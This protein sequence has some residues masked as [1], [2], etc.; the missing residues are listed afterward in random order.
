MLQ[1][2]IF[3]LKLASID[4]A[5]KTPDVSGAE[6]LALADAYYKWVTQEVREAEEAKNQQAKVV[7]LAK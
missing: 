7:T 4:L 2:Q 3:Q 1:E 6:A 5:N